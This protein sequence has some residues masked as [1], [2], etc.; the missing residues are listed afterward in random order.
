MSQKISQMHDC[1]SQ[2]N[3]LVSV[4]IP[5]YNVQSYLAECLDSVIHQTLREIEI[6]CIND[7][8]TDRSGEILERYAKEDSRIVAIHK[9]N[10]G[11]ASA[12][13][14]ALYL[15]K[16]A[17]VCFIDADD[18]YPS[19][20][21]LATLYNAAQQHQALICGGCFSDYLNGTINTDFP[22][23]LYGYT[24]AH[25]GFV[26]YK[27]YQFDFGWTRFLYN[28]IFLLNEHILHPHYTRYEDPVFFVK[29]MIAAQ[30]FYALSEVTYCYRIGHQKSFLAWSKTH[31]R[32]QNKGLLDVLILAQ[33]HRLDKLYNLTLERAHIIATHLTESICEGKGSIESLYMLHMILSAKDNEIF[34]LQSKAIPQA[35]TLEF[36]RIHQRLSYLNHLLTSP[37][38]LFM[39]ILKCYKQNFKC[40]FRVRLFKKYS[41]IR[42]F[43]ITLYE[44]FVDTK[45]TRGGGGYNV[46]PY[47]LYSL[48]I[49]LNGGSFGRIGGVNAR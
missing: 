40:Y 48:Y 38:Q 16:G 4:I 35:L 11:V 23:I 27:D 3:P 24:F 1:K 5:I 29:A 10:A 37:L 22:S 2:N 25:N 21:T 45:I 18:F 8:S 43:G 39:L 7:G 20:Q 9:A 42:I 36:E 14:E 13:N 30:R 15:A 44:R 46:V 12:R 6:I 34:A 47:L 26:E 31:W 17:F 49:F 32:D 33:T 19:N 28:R 41:V